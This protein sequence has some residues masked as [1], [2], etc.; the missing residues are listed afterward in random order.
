[1][2]DQP[3]LGRRYRVVHDEFQGVVIGFYCRLDGYPGTVLQQD[4]TK[5]VH[6]YGN[7]WLVPVAPLLDERS[8]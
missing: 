5:V 7:R 2:T 1:M 3:E 4:G 6:V 8:P